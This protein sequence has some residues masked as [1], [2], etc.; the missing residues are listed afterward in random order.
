[1]SVIQAV[2]QRCCRQVTEGTFP[3]ETGK[4]LCWGMD[5]GSLLQ[6]ERVSGS[7]WSLRR[8]RRAGGNVRPTLSRK[9]GEER[10]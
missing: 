7:G 1:M 6:A 3:G 2:V 9:I 8:E 5:R 4:G 10:R